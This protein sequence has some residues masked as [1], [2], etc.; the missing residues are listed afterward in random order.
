MLQCGMFVPEAP[1][2][3]ALCPGLFTHCKREEDAKMRSGKLDEEL[4][5]MSAIVDDLTP[6]SMILLNESFSATNER[7]GSEIGRQIVSALLEKR[8]R[9]FFVTHQ[10][11]LA[12]GFFD[13]RMGDAMF[14]R[15]ERR[16]DGTRTF[17]MIEGEPLETSYG[18]DLYRAIFTGGA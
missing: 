12:R 5:R 10:Y 13:R 8:I 4:A 6:D 1:F 15:A 7:E 3:A 11:Q 18:K 17:R 14:L 16:E 9:V 2:S